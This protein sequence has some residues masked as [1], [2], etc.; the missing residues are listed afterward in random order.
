MLKRLRIY[1]RR[2]RWIL[3]ISKELANIPGIQEASLW[4]A[5][6][7]LHI[8]IEMGIYPARGTATVAIRDCDVSLRAFQREAVPQIV[9]DMRAEAAKQKHWFN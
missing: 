2:R 3:R 8:E 4:F 5:D 1:L 6:G 9:D 7:F